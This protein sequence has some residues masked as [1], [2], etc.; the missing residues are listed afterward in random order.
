[1]I[2]VVSEDRSVDVHLVEAWHHLLAFQH[3]AHH[4]GVE[5][6]ST[7]QD[8]SIATADIAQLSREARCATHRLLVTWLD[9]V[10]IV[11]V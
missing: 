1:V 7:K 5:R 9:V 4:R 3:R 2:T 10:D 8:Q 6:I 11:E